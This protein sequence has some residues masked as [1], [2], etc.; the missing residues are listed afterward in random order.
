MVIVTGHG[1]RE[2]GEYIATEAASWVTL[3]S[4]EHYESRNLDYSLF[5]AAKYLQEA[6]IYLE[7][8]MLVPGEIIGR[9]RTSKADMT[10]CVESAPVD[11]K[12]DTAVV[13][14]G[15][16]VTELVFAEHGHLDLSNIPG[17]VGEL[18]CAVKLSALASQDLA[19]R[20]AASAMVG[21]MQLYKLFEAMLNEFSSAYVTTDG[22]P[23]IEI[24]AHEDLERAHKIA[25]RVAQLAQPSIEPG[26]TRQN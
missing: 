23:W 12:I 26:V 11:H 14:C 10:F 17:A 22:L 5:T 9:L 19:A 13:A 25:H 18:L 15:Q 8:D 21:P 3:L 20:L 24:D 2:I 7:G 16:E 1:G 6:I 4:N